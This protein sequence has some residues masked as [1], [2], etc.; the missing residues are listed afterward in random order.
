MIVALVLAACARTTPEPVL[1]PPVV[2]APSPAPVGVPTEGG[3][4]LVRVEGRVPDLVVVV[5][6]PDHAPVQDAVLA[7]V[8][9]GEGLLVD[10]GECDSV[11]E[12]RCDHLDGRY[13][14]VAPRG[15]AP[16]PAPSGRV[17]IAVDGD[18]GLDRVV[19]PLP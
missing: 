11:G 16:A 9:D 2:E 17:A 8:V 15:W 10:P 6:T 4:Y 7:V 18:A 19:I 13:A 12:V 5:T 3:H 1:A 14:C